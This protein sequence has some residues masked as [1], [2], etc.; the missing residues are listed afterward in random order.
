MIHLLTYFCR[1]RGN[2]SAWTTPY[3]LTLSILGLLPAIAQAQAPA[4]TVTGLPAQPLIGETFCIDVNFTNAAVTTGYGPY[5]I[6]AIDGGVTVLSADFVDI[7]PMVE[8][9]GIFDATGV[10]IDPISAL[11]ISGNL[12]G[13]ATIVRYPVGS[14]QQGASALVMQVC[15]VVDVGAAIGVPLDVD[16][17]PGFEF[18]DT[19]TG[20]NGAILGSPTLGLVTPQLA[21]VEK[22]NTAPEGERPPGPSHVFNYIWAVEVSEG[23]T[24]D[25]VLLRDNLPADIQWTGGLINISSPLGT[26]CSVTTIPNT[27]NTPA[28]EAVV[29]CLSVTGSSAAG[30]LTVSVPVYIADILDEAVPD[31][32]PITNIVDLQYSYQGT[33]YAS[34]DNSE[35]LAVHAAAQ[36][37]VSGTPLPGQVLTYTVDF[38]L[39]DYPDDPNTPGAGALDFVLGDVIPN[40]MSF[41]GTISLIVNGSPVAIT[42]GSSANTPGPGQTTVIWDIGSA[43]GAALPNGSKGTLLYEASVLSV[44]ADGVTPVQ[45]ADN[46]SNDI[47]LSYGLTEGASGN[48]GSTAPI[49]ITPNSSDKAVQDPSP[50]PP[51]LMPGEEIT[52]RL[53]MAFP[54]GSSSNVVFIDNLPRP[55]FDVA[56]F[57]VVTDWTVLPPFAGL[58]PTVTKNVAENRVTLDFG[59]I[60][61]G[62]GATLTVDLRATITGVPFSDDLFLTNLFSSS[63]ENAAGDVIEGLQAVA[64]TVG[65]PELVITKGVFSV[66]NPRA[67]ITP[68]PPGDPTSALVEGEATGVDGFDAIVYTITVENIGSQ[69]AYGVTVRDVTPLGLT[70]SPLGAAD[71]INGDGIPLA[72]SGDPYVAPGITLVAPLAGND[73]TPGAQFST[74]TAIITV[75]CSLDASVTPAETITNL[76]RVDWVSTPGG[77]EA[78]PTGEDDASVTISSPTVV[79]TVI[80]AEPGY[81]GNPRSLHV[82]EIATYQLDITVPEGTSPEVKLED[83]LD[84]GLAH[85][86]VVSISATS[87]LSTSLGSFDP[88]VFANVGYLSNGSGDS[89]PDR[90]MVF[91]PSGSQNG[92]GTVSNVNSN[93]NVDDVISVIYRARVLNSLSNV[94]GQQL[95]NRA[96]WYWQPKGLDRRYVQVRA[97]SISIVEPDLSLS[98]EFQPNT[99][100]NLSPPLVVIR[101]THSSGS[102]AGAF[103][104]NFV[105]P[106]PADMGILGGAGGVTLNN[107]P[108]TTRLEVVRSAISDTLFIDWA[109]L[110]TS[111][112]TCIISFQSEFLV[113]VVAGVSLNN[114][115]SVNWQSLSGL[116]QPLASPPN[117]TI[118]VE[119][120]GDAGDPGGSANN[121]TREACDTYKVFDVG[122]NKTVIDTSQAHTDNIPGTPAGTESLTIGEVVTFGLTVTVPEALSVEI[123][124]TDALP[125]TAMVLDLISAD[126]AFVG[127]D[128]SP[129]VD[130]PVPLITDTSGDGYNDTV[131]LD[132]G[133]VGHILDGVTDDKD[134]IQIEV[135]AKVVDVAAN[136]NNDIDHNSAV[137]RFFPNLSSSDDY[138]VELVEPLLSLEKIADTGRVE[139]GDEVLYSLG[140][141]HRNS[142][143]TDAQDVQL[144]DALPP[145]LTLVPGSAAVSADC[146]VAPTVGPIGAGGNVSAQ[147]DDF[148]LAGMCSIEFRATVNISAITGQTIVNDASINWT[149]LDTQGD[150][151]DRVYTFDDS[152]S[153]VVSQPGLTKQL[154]DTSIPDTPFSLGARFHALTIGE[155]ATFTLQVDFPDGTTPL[156]RVED[157]LPDMGVALAF[158]SSRIVSLGGDL[159]FSTSPVVGDAAVACTPADSSCLQ[160]VLGE[161]VN[162]PDSRANPDLED[163]VVFEVEAIVLDDLLN[164]GAPGE[165][166]NLLNTGQLK[167]PSGS[168]TATDKFDLVEPLLDIKKLTEDGS[169]EQTT[170]AG[171]EHRFSLVI[172][173]D[174]NSTATAHTVLVTDQLAPQMEWVNDTSVSSTCPALQIEGSPLPGASGL[175]VFSF[176]KLPIENKRCTISFTVKMSNILPVPGVYENT[177]ALDWESA[178]GSPES[179]KYSDSSSAKL[180]AYSDAFMLKEISATSVPDTGTGQGDSQLEDA[181]IGEIIEYRIVA[182]FTEGRTDNVIIRD[183]FQNDTAGQFE[184]VGAGVDSVGG[185]ITA[186]NPSLPIVVGNVVTIDYG[187]VINVADGISDTNDTIVYRLEL[188]VTNVAQNMTGDV[189]INDAQLQYDDTFSVPQFVDDDAQVDVVEPVLAMT[190]TF[191]NLQLDVATI[192][193]DI[194]NTGTSS[195]YDLIVSDEF[196]EAIWVP[197]SLMSV[198]VPSGYEIIETSSAGVTTVSVKVKT[199]ATPPAP[200]EVLSPGETAT[201]VFNMTLQNQGQPGP[202]V[203]PNTAQLEAT[204]LPG[205][206]SNERVYNTDATDTLLLPAIDLEKT[207]AG[208]ANPA[209]PGDTLTY[210]LTLK[211]TG[212]GPVTN[213][214]ITDTPDAIGEFQVGSVLA[215]GGTVLT[216]NTPGDISVEANYA[217]V[218]GGA[219]VTLNYDVVV[220]LPYA[221]GFTHPEELVNQGAASS[222]E[223]S[224]ILSDDPDTSA[225]DDP[226]IVPIVADPVMTVAKDDQVLIGDPGDTLVYAIEYG[227]SG[228][229]DAS[230]VVLTETV[231]DNTVFSVAD[232]TAGWVCLAG[233][234]AGDSCSLTIGSMSGAT[235]ATA[236]FGVVIDDPVPAGVV[237]IFNEIMIEEDGEEFD[238]NAPVV[239]STDSDTE[240]TPLIA[241]PELEVFKNDGGIAVVPAQ[242]YAY[243]IYY[244]NIGNQNSTGITL[245]ETVP[246]FTSYDPSGSLP[247]TWVCAAGGFAGDTCRL[248]GGDLSAG[249]GNSVKFGLSV[250]YP[251]PALADLIL[252]TVDLMDD[253]T[254]SLGVP[255]TDQAMDTTPLLA[256]PDLT[257]TKK[258]DSGTIH[259]KDIVTYTLDYEN[260]G[261]QDATGAVVR[262]VVP[263]GTVFSEADSMPTVWSCAD[264]AAAGSVCDYT[265]GSLPVGASGQLAFAVMAVE[266]PDSQNVTNIAIISND[267]SNGVD[268][269][270]GNNIAKVVNS[271]PIPSIP[272]LNWAWL[273]L[274]ALSMIGVAGRAQGR[275]NQG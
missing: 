216:G 119:R 56:D 148:P 179:R 62:A 263:P 85:V 169:A 47:E 132:Y 89:A 57:D 154:T 190:K 195:A 48:N 174:A 19:A 152:W 247:S 59:D 253:G 229:Q 270:P 210:I 137:V 218:S 189:L 122:I 175:V 164:S 45:A 34:A 108:A 32:Q 264:G 135:V 172:E 110:T 106:M 162:Q 136:A 200:N 259:V 165:D 215:L 63:Y 75:N 67:I 11:P 66:D 8:P 166:K 212:D 55:V 53:T 261:N 7:P 150:P 90:E 238:P 78:F 228:N 35:V 33:D 181:A 168:L 201:I 87:G 234:V 29:E 91:G 214:V 203:I 74:D 273:M 138:P 70:C 125:K 104:L 141:R 114:C 103:D 242:D 127:I 93:N 52:F 112:G 237:S 6:G 72:F 149:S 134:R 43:L 23:V 88:D 39:T 96:R 227:N 102:N 126:T 197:G 153:L 232:S 109:D 42:P 12:G 248:D 2:C 140:I 22:S 258:S 99:G 266:I 155:R 131:T 208:P 116:D 254:N 231:P 183:T 272:V 269:T 185:N 184:L 257:I 220:P 235:L 180:V 230:G 170:V 209:S 84:S 10:I 40:G 24:V 25:A 94:N 221:D 13:Q 196:D 115:A 77:S 16:I 219:S 249:F 21:R 188:R 26:G 142:S 246:E 265:I 128:L 156:V 262:E 118:G 73:G 61:A 217:S 107:C 41:E 111:S 275:S 139:A 98:K 204:S 144:S 120:T 17:T 226:T 191:T 173:H 79:K 268:P 271:F 256:V 267:G 157:M 14:V 178:P 143:R 37:T 97:N 236:L 92:F 145:E 147:W 129:D 207:W 241:Q 182:K 130:A 206:D 192:K 176:E 186:T 65:A 211:N 76:A 223:L 5:L 64:I 83:L 69:S 54:A 255:L 95:K 202:T 124:V 86:D 260:V 18:G 205:L 213:V 239:P 28:G 82:G 49:E 15:L 60:N 250:V 161:V 38:Q 193:L 20:D 222:T 245:T 27:P 199:P 44:Y 244:R 113:P 117:N 81:S 167:S 225:V 160:W 68:P 251:V 146:T 252:N 46:L 121:Y 243:L 158:T 233:G 58:T 3:L 9:I 101:L 159:S 163:A 100:D 4:I 30:D 105:D 151:D 177:V 123:E 194:S 198:A 80:D 240:T 171:E 1:R 51:T 274:L 187:S 31:Q 50:L 71:V 36:K 133:S 224:A